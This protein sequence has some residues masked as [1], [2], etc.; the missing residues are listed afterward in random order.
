ML[1]YLTFFFKQWKNP[2]KKKQN[3]NNNA[4]YIE[5]NFHKFKVL[6]IY[7][8]NRPYPSFWVYIVIIIKTITFLYNFNKSICFKNITIY[9]EKI[10]YTRSCEILI[11][12]P[13][14]F[15]FKLH[16][17]K[18]SNFGQF[19]RPKFWSSKA[20]FMREYNFYCGSTIK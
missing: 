17:F 12:I 9:H 4:I 8:K 2:F 7:I 14:I 6:Y 10:I 13:L 1:R 5:Y 18:N 20:W 19:Y 15:Y 11:V 3:V 16:V